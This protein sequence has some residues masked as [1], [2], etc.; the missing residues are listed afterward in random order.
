[1][2]HSIPEAVILSDRVLIM[3]SRPSTITAEIIIPF[4]RP[5]SLSLMGKAEFAGICSEIRQ[6]IEAGYAR[7]A[8]L[9]AAQD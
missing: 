4:S 2:T 7:G 8:E 6:H 9:Q 3:D 5:R 1:M